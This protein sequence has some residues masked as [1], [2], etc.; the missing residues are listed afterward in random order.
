[1]AQKELL[2]AFQQPA[3]SKMTPSSIDPSGM[4]MA[5]KSD[6]EIYQKHFG[7]HIEKHGERWRD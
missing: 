4:D 1:V 7:L 2:G 5:L 6:A 3:Y